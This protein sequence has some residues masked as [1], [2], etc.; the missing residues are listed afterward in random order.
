MKLWIDLLTD[1]ER[2]EFL[3]NGDATK[4]GIIAPAITDDIIELLKFRMQANPV[5]N[6]VSQPSEFSVCEQIESN[7][8]EYA[9][10]MQ[11]EFEQYAH[12]EDGVDYGLGLAEGKQLAAHIALAKVNNI[13]ANKPVHRLL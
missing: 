2:I 4:T 1:E 7:L 12:K 8:F 13:V 6:R 11:E 3:Q 5:E 10:R 9:K